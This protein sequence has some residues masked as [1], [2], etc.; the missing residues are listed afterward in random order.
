MSKALPK[1]EWLV[2]IFDNAA[3]Q[4]LAF[5]TQHLAALRSNIESGVVTSGGPLFK[6]GAKTNPF[7]SII[8][9]RANSRAEVVKFLKQ[10]IYAEKKVW[11]FD[12]LM[13]H[14]CALRYR[15]A[16]EWPKV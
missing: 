2:V 16:I 3:G 13:V 11:N 9:I 14:P 1:L 6:D 15:S 12:T 5:K 4:R 10:D 7:G 8:T